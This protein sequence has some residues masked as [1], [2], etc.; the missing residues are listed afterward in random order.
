MG[1][2][3]LRRKRFGNAVH[4]FEQA[5]NAVYLAAICDRLMTEYSK[6]LKQTQKKSTLKRNDDDSKQSMSV[7]DGDD[8]D[9]ESAGDDPLADIEAVVDN[10]SKVSLSHE[11]AFLGKYRDLCLIRREIAALDRV[12]VQVMNPSK[13]N[14]SSSTTTNQTL[15]QIADEDVVE[16]RTNMRQLICAAVEI[17][18]RVLVFRV[19]PRKYWLELLLDIVPLLERSDPLDPVLSLQDTGRLLACLEEFCNSYFTQAQVKASRHS[20]QVVRLALGKNAARAGKFSM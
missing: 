5:N 15:S 8:D 1:R 2:A 7:D 16:H 14:S 4:W 3:A 9:A 12:G 11:L 18:V 20:I 6:K 19:A 17:V 13:G 10:F